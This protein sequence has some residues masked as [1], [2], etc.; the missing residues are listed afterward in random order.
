MWSHFDGRIDEKAAATGRI[1][2][3]IFNGGLKKALENLREGSR[4]LLQFR[5]LSLVSGKVTREGSKIERVLV[6]EGVIQTA[7]PK[8]HALNK[9]LNR[10]ALISLFPEQVDGFVQDLLRQKRFLSR[11]RVAVLLSFCLPQVY[12]ILERK[13]KD[14]EG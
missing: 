10:S 9:V 13:V 3:Q 2:E 12:T 8:A 11:H 4:L 5:D 7:A 14:V 1:A 6:A